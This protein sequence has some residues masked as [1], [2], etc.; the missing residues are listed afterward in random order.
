MEAVDAVEAKR[1]KGDNRKM[2]LKQLTEMLSK[3]KTLQSNSDFEA[4]TFGWGLP[5]N[6]EKKGNPNCKKNKA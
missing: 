1:D 5:A 2:S 4:E 3:D 6:M